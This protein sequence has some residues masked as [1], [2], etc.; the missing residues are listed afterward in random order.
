MS[1]ENV[2]YQLDYDEVEIP[3]EEQKETTGVASAA[4]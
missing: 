1:T 3:E 2:E 4:K